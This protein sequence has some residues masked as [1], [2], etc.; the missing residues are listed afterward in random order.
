MLLCEYVIATAA[1]SLLAVMTAADG[2]GI[3]TFVLGAVMLALF[4]IKPKVEEFYQ[5]LDG[6][7]GL[8]LEL[9][10]FWMLV[11]GI[12]YIGIGVYCWL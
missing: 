11:L 7:P 5:G 1:S 8:I 6:I 12:A 4:Y 2:D 9:I 10:P 3:R